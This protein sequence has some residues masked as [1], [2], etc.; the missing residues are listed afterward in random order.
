MK[1]STKLNRY[2]SKLSL[3]LDRRFCSTLP[4]TRATQFGG[5]PICDSTAPMLQRGILRAS[6]CPACDFFSWPWRAPA[7]FSARP[8]APIAETCLKGSP[9]CLS[10]ERYK[11]TTPQAQSCGSFPKASKRAQMTP[12]QP[13]TLAST[14]RG[15]AHLSQAVTSCF[16]CFKLGQ[17]I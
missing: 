9:T 5:C 4:F 14:F 16:F 15:V 11:E 8:G 2:G 13:S 12:S 17:G 7:A 1:R 3:S 6:W 10:M